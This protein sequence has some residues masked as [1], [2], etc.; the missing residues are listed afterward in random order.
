MS[1]PGAVRRAASASPP[2]APP[3]DRSFPRAVRLLARRDFLHVYDRG[4]RA[5]GP[6]LVL[7]AA[8]NGLPWSRLGITVSRKF[9]GAVARNRMKRRIREIF[10][11]HRNALP[12]GLD[13]VVNVR[14]GA[15]A[16]PYSRLEG[17]FCDQFRSV[18]RR[19]G[20]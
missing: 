1:S 13:L 5:A 11:T 2:D 4:L 7:F 19:S 12:S 15:G 10:R 17:E 3:A 6:S 18:A 8:P 16:V 9:G 14:P 20:A